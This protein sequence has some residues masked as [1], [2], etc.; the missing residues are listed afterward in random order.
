LSKTSHPWKKRVGKKSRWKWRKKRRR[1]M[2]R[3]A[4]RI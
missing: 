2:Q 1:K 4:R 3:K